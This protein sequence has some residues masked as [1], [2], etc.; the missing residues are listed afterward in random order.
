MSVIVD[1]M[2]RIPSLYLADVLADDILVHARIIDTSG[3]G[4]FVLSQFLLLQTTMM[5]YHD[6][7]SMLNHKERNI[8]KF[9][10]RF[11]LFIIF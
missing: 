9:K 6:Y 11:T 1:N 7:F 5:L 8:E 10:K 3:L 4:L 2:S